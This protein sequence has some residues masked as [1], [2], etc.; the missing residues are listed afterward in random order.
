MMRTR[1]LVICVLALAGCSAVPEITG[2]PRLQARLAGPTDITLTWQA[3]DTGHVVEFATDPA[4]PWTILAFAPPGQ[5]SYEHQ[6]LI[7]HTRFH[8]RLRPYGGPTSNAVEVSLP[9]GEL[10]P[11]ADHAW[12]DPQVIRTG[13]VTTGPRGTPGGLRATIVHANGIRFTWTDHA[14]DEEGYLLESGERVLALLDP[15]VNAFGIVTLPEEKRASYRVRALYYGPPSNLATQ[16]TGAD[17]SSARGSAQDLGDL[18]GENRMPAASIRAEPVTT[19]MNRSVM[20]SQTGS[21][22]RAL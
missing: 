2:T 22:G 6:E 1:L 19:Q 12:A 18:L 3:G 16:T 13:P 17:P 7:P 21:E 8:Y 4:G 15:D 5:T 9:P 10:D 20:G 11:G 14:S